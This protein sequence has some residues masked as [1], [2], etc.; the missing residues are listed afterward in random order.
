MSHETIYQYIW[1]DKRKDGILYKHL[2]HNGKKYNR[3]Q[4]GEAGRGC[5]TNRIGIEER[6]EMV[7]KKYRVGDWELEVLAIPYGGPNK[8]KDNQGEF[9]NAQ[10]NLYLDKFRD[11]FVSYYHTFG[12]D[13]KPQA[14]P[15]QI[16]KV[17]SYECK[18]YG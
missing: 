9:F 3:R 4:S 1:K 6:T 13:G 12:P 14:D 18:S 17:V 7:A 11:P 15:V 10:T 5:I 2:R 8:G 16:A